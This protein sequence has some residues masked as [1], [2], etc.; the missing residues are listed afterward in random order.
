MD[1][2]QVIYVQNGNHYIS[3]DAHQA[4]QRV[5]GGVEVISIDHRFSNSPSLKTINQTSSTQT[6]TT[7]RPTVYTNIQ[8]ITRKSPSRLYPTNPPRAETTV[9]KKPCAS[10]GGKYRGNTKYPIP[11]ENN[12]LTCRPHHERPNIITQPVCSISESESF[13]RRNPN[14]THVHVHVLSQVPNAMLAKR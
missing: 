10:L 2:C 6:P 11:L 9:A 5:W 1:E 3:T 13:G 7:K 8:S 14:R 12:S 4:S